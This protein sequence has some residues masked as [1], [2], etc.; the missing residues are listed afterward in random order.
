MGVVGLGFG[1][2]TNGKTLLILGL[3]IKLMI[4]ALLGLT[5]LGHFD[6]F[7]GLIGWVFGWLARWA[8]GGN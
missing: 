3:L 4:L 7:P 8:G 6:T 5:I 1:S 2:R